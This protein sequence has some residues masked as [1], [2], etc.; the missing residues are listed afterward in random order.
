[1]KYPIYIISK[2]RSSC[3]LTARMFERDGV[4]YRLVV[5][6]QELD[7]YSKEFEKKKI[8]VLPFSNLGLG[9]IP[10]RNWVWE[11]SINN[12]H[13]RHWIFDDNISF[14]C[15]RIDAKRKKCNSGDAIEKIEEFVDRYDNIAISGMNYRFFVP[16]F[17]KYPPFVRNVHVYSNLF[18]KNDLKFRWRGRY[19]E[20]TD[21][22]LQVLSS[23]LCTVLFNAFLINKMGTMTMKGGNSDELYKGDGR[24]KMA[25]SLKRMWPGVVDVKRRFKRPQHVINKNWRM[26]DQQLKLK[27]NQV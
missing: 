24:L 15:Q 11:H 25:N 26:F 16:D 22:C 17:K 19:N 3:C 20:D 8:F 2:G 12:G 7:L 27:N 6:P 21:L 1:M 23:G 18:I 9:G 13:K 5:E 4:D 10:A 14:V